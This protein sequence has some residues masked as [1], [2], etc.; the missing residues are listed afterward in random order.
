MFTAEEFYDNF[1]EV[2]DRLQVYNFSFFLFEIRIVWYLVSS[3]F[4]FIRANCEMVKAYVGFMFK[5]SYEVNFM[6]TSKTK[7]VELGFIIY[8]NFLDDFDLMF[9]D[10]RSRW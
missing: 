6:L 4:T 8:L 10:K 1:V 2:L 7:A 3:T 9:I 5:S